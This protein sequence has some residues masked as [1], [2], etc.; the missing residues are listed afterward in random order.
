MFKYS[1]AVAKVLLKMISKGLAE[2]FKFIL[3]LFFMVSGIANVCTAFLIPIVAPFLWDE[4]SYKLL[5]WLT[6]PAWSVLFVALCAEIIC[7]FKEK[8]KEENTET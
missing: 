2:L 8:L 4:R 6:I 7:I 5:F 3:A 1:V